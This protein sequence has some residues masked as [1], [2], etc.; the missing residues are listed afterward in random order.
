MEMLVPTLLLSLQRENKTEV[1]IIKK[2]NN[3]GKERDTGQ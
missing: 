2:R 3:H 1:S